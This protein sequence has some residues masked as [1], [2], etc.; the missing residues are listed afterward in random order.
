MAFKNPKYNSAKYIARRDLFAIG[1]TFRILDEQKNLLLFS[2]QKLFKLKEDIRVFA[3]TNMQEEILTIKAQQIIDFAAAYDV[4][5][6]AGLE[7]VGTIRRRGW[8]S[9]L[10]DHWEILDKRGNLVASVKEDHMALALIRRFLMNLIPQ[11][12]HIETVDGKRVGVMKQ[13]FN[14]FLHIFDIDL[15]SDKLEMLLDRRIIMAAV[16]LLLAIEGKQN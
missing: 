7:V 14:P 11:T 8:K 6:S 9:M 12:Y 2:K 13:R 15:S 16:I 10:Q 1:G 3:D 5:D 4:R